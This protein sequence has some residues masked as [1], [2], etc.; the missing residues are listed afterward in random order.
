MTG[1]GSRR[2]VLRRDVVVDERAEGGRELLVGALQRRE[3]LAVDVDGAVRL[4]ARSGQRD[5]DRGGLRLAGSVD[6]AAH[7]RERHVLDTLVLR[8]PDRHLV[9]DVA[10]DALGELLERRR[11]RAPAARARGHARREGADAERLEQLARRVDLLAAVAARSGRQRDADRVADALVQQN[12]HRRGGPDETLHAHARL[13]QAE[14]ERL[15]GARGELAVDGDEV[16][17]PGDLAGDD[18]LV[19]AQAR[20]ERE[21]GRLEGGEDHA[22][23]DDFLGRVPE[24]LVRVLLHLLHDELLVQGAAVDAD[25]DGLAVVDARSCRSSRTARRAARPCRRCPG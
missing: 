3:V 23:V 25:A 10:L 5:A 19:L 7:D 6:D 24:V 14:V 12:A 11:G 2:R 17:R 20:L 16:E 8:L 4:L 22:F 1:F 18:D 13:G 21:L 9:A 15:I